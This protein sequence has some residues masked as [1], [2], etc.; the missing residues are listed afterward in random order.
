MVGRSFQ[1]LPDLLAKL[2]YRDLT[3][4]VNTAFQ[5]VHKTPLSPFA[6]MAEHPEV[7]ADFNEWLA[8]HRKDRAICWDVY[9]IELETRGWDFNA[10]V[11]VDIG[12]NIGHQCAEFK[13]RFP[14]VPGHVILEDLEGPISMALST[15]GVEN[16]VHDIFKPQPIKGK[17]RILAYRAG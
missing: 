7:A 5:V 16:K 12:G 13:K 17:L 14:R 4:H 10:T 11:L 2:E 8:Y 9:P 1:E 3:D 6:W 15:P